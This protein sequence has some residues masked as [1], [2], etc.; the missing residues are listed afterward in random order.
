VESES[1]P[2]A[3]ERAVD[4]SVIE[5]AGGYDDDDPAFPESQDTPTAEAAVRAPET[6]RTWQREPRRTPLPPVS[7]E[8][9]EEGRPE[10]PMEERHVD[11]YAWDQ[12]EAPAERTPRSGGRSVDPFYTRT[13]REPILEPEPEPEFEAVSESAPDDEDD[14]PTT[15]KP[16]PQP[17]PPATPEAGRSFGR[18][19]GRAR[20]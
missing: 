16:N 19:P 18:R 7:R 14:V 10:G 2:S 15:A 1:V 8:F 11:P 17:Q 3:R 5:S 12:G 20:R 6:A 4:P 13:P 9:E